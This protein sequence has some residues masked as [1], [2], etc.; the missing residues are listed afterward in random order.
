MTIFFKMAALKTA[1]MTALVLAGVVVSGT[2]H[3]QSAAPP[4]SAGGSRPL[5]APG[6]Q[7][8]SAADLAKI[9]IIV[10]PYKPAGLS[11]NDAKMIKR[12][13]RDAGF[14]RSRELDAAL[15]SAGFSA[16]KMDLLDPPPPRPP[17]EGAPPPPSK[18]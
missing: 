6:P 4:P 9:K 16:E 13:L 15:S 1:L 14:R 3:S 7:V 11:A 2:A 5:G 8:L 18:K 17:G 10:A 12:T